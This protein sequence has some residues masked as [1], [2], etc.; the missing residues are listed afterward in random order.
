L[1]KVKVPLGTVVRQLEYEWEDDWMPHESQEDIYRN[2]DPRILDLLKY[3]RFR[4]GYV[5]QEDR[6]KMLLERMP[7]KSKKKKP[8]LEID[9]IEEGQTHLVFRGGKGGYGNPHFKSPLIQG[10]SM[11]LLIHFR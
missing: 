1:P 5:P 7:W 9:F 10:I 8:L 11:C 3:F 6:I 2:G 4:K